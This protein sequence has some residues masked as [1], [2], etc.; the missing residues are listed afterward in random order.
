M[1]L[2]TQSNR[3]HG[4]GFKSRF[5]CSADM[6]AQYVVAIAIVILG[7]VIWGL[8]K[9]QVL[10]A[11]GKIT[12]DEILSTAIEAE[13]VSDDAVKEIQAIV[14]K[15][16]AAEAEAAAAEAAEVETDAGN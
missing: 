7:V 2:A 5:S 8:K 4:A 16:K 12:L 15:S 13:D 11:D 10:N 3:C 9:Y 14:E 6:E 1:I